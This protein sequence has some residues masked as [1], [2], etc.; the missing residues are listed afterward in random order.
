MVRFPTDA[1]RKTL[2]PIFTAR[3]EPPLCE[4]LMSTPD[5]SRHPLAV[6]VVDDSADTAE[7]LAEVLRHYGHT[8]RV[9]FD[10]E[11]ALQSVATEVPDVVFLDILMPGLNGCEVASLIR[12]RCA[13]RKQPLLIAIT[14]CATDADRVRSAGAGFDLHLIK[15]VDPALIVGL[16]ERF[17]R[18]LAPPIPADQLEQPSEDPPDDWSALKLGH[19]GRRFA[20]RD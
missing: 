12:E 16:T 11:S 15:P 2:H 17:R 14:G 18:L 6:L 7:S 10:G 9:A 20:L 1:A 8:A 4:C 13:G 3:L 5:R 19:S